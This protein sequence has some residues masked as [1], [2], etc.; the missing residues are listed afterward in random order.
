[1][2]RIVNVPGT[3]L[4]ASA[5]HLLDDLAAGITPINTEIETIQSMPPVKDWHVL[6]GSSGQRVFYSCSGNSVMYWQYC[7][8]RNR[9]V[10]GI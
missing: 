7:I 10:L 3:F 8:P 2:P 6:Y 4:S 9:K 1:M 5:I